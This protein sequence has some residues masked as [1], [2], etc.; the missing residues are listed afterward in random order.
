M[1]GKPLRLLMVAAILAQALPA[2]VHALTDRTRWPQE[3]SDLKADPAVIYGRLP[4]GMRYI[5]YPS[6]A[7]GQGVSMRFRIHAGSIDEASGQ[8]G[9]AHFVEHMA[10]KGSA[11]LPE[12]K[13]TGLLARMG[14]N[15]GSD[16]NAFTDFE[17]TDYVFD[18]P[19]WDDPLVET[20][21]AI[22]R[23]T[24]SNLSF[25][26]RA[27]DRER[28]V[29]LAE[30]RERAT[31]DQRAS[32]AYD[33]AAFTGL[34][35]AERWPIGKAAVV[36][37]ASRDDLLRFYRTH[38]RPDNATLIVVGPFEAAK[39]EGR[40]RAY[41]SDWTATRPTD[42]PTPPPLG[43]YRPQ[44]LRAYSHI[45]ANQPETVSL[46]WFRPF[47]DGVDSKASRRTGLLKAIALDILNARLNEGARAS[48]SPYL[49]AQA[50]Y[51]NERLTANST[52]LYISPRPGQTVE[53]IEA[54]T[55]RLGQYRAHGVTGPE[56]KQSMARF[57][58][59]NRREVLARKTFDHPQ[60][61][62]ELLDY[63]DH[64]DVYTGPEQFAA[65]WDELSPAF[66]VE[67]VNAQIVYLFSG[68]GPLIG[69]QGAEAQPSQQNLTEAYTKAE[70]AT[71]DILTAASDVVWPYTDFG[72]PVTEAQRTE[73]KELGYVRR[74]Y[75]NGV[76]FNFKASDVEQN[77]VLVSVR[78][79]GGMRLFSAHGADRLYRAWPYE[80]LT[81]GL[82]RVSLD[83]MTRIFTDKALGLGYDLDEDAT[84][85]SGDTDRD[86]LPQQMELMMAWLTDPGNR[87]ET[88]AT[89]RDNLTYMQK[90]MR[91]SPEDAM[92]YYVA[93]L[94]NGCDA[95]F[96]LPDASDIGA[97]RPEDMA[98]LIRRS[99][100]GTPIEV[101]IVGDIDEATAAAQV[102][103]TFAT[104]PPVAKTPPLAAD[105]GFPALSAKPQHFVIPHQ[106][107]ADQA[108]GLDVFPTTDAVSDVRETRRLELLAAILGDRLNT[109]L[110]ERRSA[111]YGAS[112]SNYASEV[113]KGY[114]YISAQ[115]EVEPA[116]EPLLHETVLKIAADLRRNRV[117]Q[118]ELD[119][120][121][122]PMTGRLNDNLKTH[123]EWLRVLPGLYG[124]PRW[125]LEVGVAAQLDDITPDELRE[126][127]RRYLTPDRLQRFS[128]VPETPGQ[129]PPAPTCPKP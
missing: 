75:P 110:R 104:L 99:V 50:I 54:V 79:D 58:A 69:R 70:A 78:F 106:G 63:L 120:I 24:A 125:P 128:I 72:P 29:I 80:P 41:F 32:Q 107:R 90:A 35:Y 98:G 116:M 30:E 117:S 66:T 5:L 8:E 82:G 25:N 36:R 91:A 119:K 101:T 68:D 19:G 61:A 71:P 60:I 11:N 67:A 127:A 15:Y 53:A 81:G 37:S 87:P 73:I 1:W 22:L 124:S 52:R 17:T 84:W 46:N 74:V 77:R 118:K 33:T 86:S 93:P 85:L 26:S 6:Q 21:L 123:A 27:I 122:V 38:Y 65:L 23:E 34:T 111:T 129:T 88:F 97:M 115:A 114:G 105:G 39:M 18:L 14:V 95:R 113:V 44:G 94:L 96:A 76:V 48:Q 10:F 43:Q 4:N 62:Y 42:A 83:D 57:A 64:D 2:P 89:A 121:R 45:E 51:D 100:T 112:A 92:S 28:G 102:A 12:G 13:L 40:I 126:A 49:A 103:R 9:L 108:I 20:T 56:L 59:S 16:A 47:I 31:P 109:L 3:R 7:P 55:R